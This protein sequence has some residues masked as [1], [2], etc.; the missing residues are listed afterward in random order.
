MM[1]QVFSEPLTV[2]QGVLR[3][4]L[5]TPLPTTLHQPREQG[6]KYSNPLMVKG[7]G[8]FQILRIKTSLTIVSGT[9]WSTP[10]HG[11]DFVPESPVYV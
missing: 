6:E 7:W 8:R 5:Y 3:T 1:C 10:T 4:V 9:C 11:M 2:G